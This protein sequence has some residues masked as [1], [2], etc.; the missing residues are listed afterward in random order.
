MKYP[1]DYEPPFTLKSTG[2]SPP[3]TSEELPE[4]L[5]DLPFNVSCLLWQVAG[6]SVWLTAALFYLCQ[7]VARTAKGRSLPV[8]SEFRNGR[9]RVLTV[10]R[11]VSGDTDLLSS[12]LQKLCLAATVEQ[13]GGALKIHG[14]HVERVRQ[15]LVGLGF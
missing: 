11:R 6:C 3:P 8:Y 7:Q 12:E 4:H 9:S 13:K 2:W 1:G 14:N 10:V 5:R 15:W